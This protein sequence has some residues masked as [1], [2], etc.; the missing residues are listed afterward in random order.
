MS[1]EYFQRAYRMDAAESAFLELQLEHL[2][3]RT[4]DVRYPALKGRQFVPVSNE[5]DPGAETIAYEQGDAVGR[6]KIISHNAKD[7]PRID[8]LSEK[9]TR[10]VRV[11]AD[12]FGWTRKEL[13]AASM[14]GRNLNG[15]RMRWARRAAEQTIDDICAFGAPDFG[16]PTGFVND[17]VVPQQVAGDLWTVAT[18]D[19]IIDDM[20]DAV[21]RIVEATEDTDEPDTIVLPPDRHSLI[22]TR[23]RSANSDKTILEFVL[24]AFPSITAIEKWN[25][26]QSAGTGSTRRMIVYKRSPENLEQDIPE[27]FN[28]LE[29]QLQGL[30]T[31]IN[32]VAQT[33]GM[34]FYQPFTADYTDTI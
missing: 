32:A 5:A 23:P 34:V 13:Q 30:D 16:I 33:A 27:E 1:A 12:A 28:M 7:I 18:P 15:R 21:A 26:L 6:A 24:S 14:T 22:S 19:E 3:A 17:A 25:R 20:G 31:V 2:K 10:P 4:F 9:F 11:I 8:V 29:P